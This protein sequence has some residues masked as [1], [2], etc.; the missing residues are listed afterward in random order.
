MLDDNF[1][2]QVQNFFENLALLPVP[3]VF[4]GGSRD[5]LL[6][7]PSGP[8]GPLYGPAD[9]RFSGCALPA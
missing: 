5:D 6:H 4:A 7:V 9:H 2:A 1:L 3:T 8:A